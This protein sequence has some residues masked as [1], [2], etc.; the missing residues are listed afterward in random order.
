[1]LPTPSLCAHPCA[2]M[3]SGNTSSEDGLTHQ[4]VNGFRINMILKQVISN[5][6]PSVIAE[7]LNGFYSIIQKHL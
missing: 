6:K 5:G 3:D 1:M 7:K 4:L 2:V